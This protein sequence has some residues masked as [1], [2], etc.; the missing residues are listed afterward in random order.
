MNQ[1]LENSFDF[2]IRAME[3]I[4][5]LNEEKKTFLLRER[6]LVCATG[7]GISLRLTKVKND[8][9]FEEAL[10]YAVETEYLLE[11]MVKIGCLK[12]KA[13]PA[14]SGRLPCTEVRDFG[15]GSERKMTYH[16]NKSM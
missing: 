13:K 11:I 7:I 6:F 2:S 12:K 10:D 5:Y 14:H 16:I 15:A 4:R 1:L 3:L 8:K 9:S